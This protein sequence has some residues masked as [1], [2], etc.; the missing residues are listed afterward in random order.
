MRHRFILIC[1]QTASAP[2]T[3]GTFSIQ[4]KERK[5]LQGQKDRQINERKGKKPTK[6]ISSKSKSMSNV[7]CKKQI[8][9]F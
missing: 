7:K 4:Q 9:G 5:K 6:L 8:S 1:S 3:N 2:T